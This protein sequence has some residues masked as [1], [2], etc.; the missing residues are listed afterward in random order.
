Y[1]T[2]RS[3]PARPSRPSPGGPTFRSARPPYTDLP[4]MTVGLMSVNL[5]TSARTSAIAGSAS[6]AFRASADGNWKCAII[7]Y[8]AGA[9][10]F[11][12]PSISITLDAFI[13]FIASGMWVDR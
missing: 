12:T 5:G 2:A 13:T 6:A 11:D 8:G 1:Q 3:G 4:T 9:A 10:P 7:A